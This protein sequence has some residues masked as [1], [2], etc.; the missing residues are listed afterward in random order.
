MITIIG[1][2][3]C[4]TADGRNFTALI[5]Q[6][7]I[8]FVQSENGNYYITAY[9]ASVSTSLDEFVCKTLLGKQL[10]GDIQKVLCEPYEFVNKETGETTMLD[11]KYQYTPEETK[12]T[13]Q[14]M[15]FQQQQPN[16]GQ[17]VFN[18]PQQ[19]QMVNPMPFE[20]NSMGMGSMVAAEA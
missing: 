6:S 13:V 20:L 7:D 17:P 16:Y 9:K 15:A 2:K 11:W 3:D 14:P 12:P 10:Q 1:I 4:I 8:K 18:Y 19:Q 5:L